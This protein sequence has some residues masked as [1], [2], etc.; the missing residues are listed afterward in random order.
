MA[1]EEFTL[2]L[3]TEHTGGVTSKYDSYWTARLEEIRAG[4]ERATAGL[5]V[6]IGL[7]DLRGAGERESWYGVAEVCGRGVTRSSM[8]HAT[9]LGRAVA[10]SGMCAAWPGSVFRFTIAAAGDVLTI[11]TVQDGSGPSAGTAAV[12]PGR[13]RPRGAAGAGEPGHA[14]SVTENASAGDRG[15]HVPDG[16]TADRFYRMLSNR[17]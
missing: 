17:K 16:V 8:A 7:P 3:V 2:G 14:D 12:P 10:A 11:T 6:V 9:S 13:A 4:L 1:A 15:G 5:P